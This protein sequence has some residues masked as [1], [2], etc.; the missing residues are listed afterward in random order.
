MVDLHRSRPQSLLLHRK[1]PSI[2]NRSATISVGRIADINRMRPVL[3]QSTSPRDHPRKEDP[4]VIQLKPVNR[5]IRIK[6][7]RC[8]D[9]HFRTIL[10]V[11]IRQGSLR[12]ALG[13]DQRP[14]GIQGEGRTAKIQ[15]IK[16]K[17]PLGF[18][19]HR[20]SAQTIKLEHRLRIPPGNWGDRGPEI[21]LPLRRVIEVTAF[22]PQ[23]RKLP[24][25]PTPHHPHGIFSGRLILSSDRV[26][27]RFGE[28]P[29]CS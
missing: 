12:L 20:V 17:I 1:R 29:H 24:R 15:L 19:R 23:P 13:E 22:F 25:L 9:R 4:R 21:R 14:F 11:H 26:N 5:E 2:D 3:D 18:S 27:L 6:P 16:H 8:L 7:D 28:V 10:A